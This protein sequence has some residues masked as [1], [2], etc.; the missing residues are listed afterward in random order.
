[1]H[2]YTHIHTHTYITHTCIYAFI[3]THTCTPV[4]VYITN[5]IT[6]RAF[7]VPN[8]HPYLGMP[9]HIKSGEYIWFSEGWAHNTTQH[10]TTPHHTT[11]HHTTPHHAT[12]HHTTPHHTT[13]HHTT[14][15][16]TH[17]Y[18]HICLCF[19][20]RL[21]GPTNTHTYIHTYYIHTYIHT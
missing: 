17:T 16:L 10:H 7:T 6:Y 21:G 5:I 11:P 14:P 19:S 20:N 9:S 15:H 18:I 4:A 3:N 1:M 8:L 2:T 12:P 13:P